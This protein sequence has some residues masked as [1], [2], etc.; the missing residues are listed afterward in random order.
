MGRLEMEL[1]RLGRERAPEGF[2]E[3]VLDAVRADDFAP[4]ETPVGRFY[5]AWNPAG[6]S[7]V[8]LM[9]EAAFRRWFARETGRRLRPAPSVPD[10]VRARILATRGVG[11]A[12]DLR[13][14]T[15][16]ER[17]V[18]MKTLEIP[19]GEVRTYAWVAKE[20]GHPRA[21][22]AV[23][24]ALAQNP[25]PLLIPCHRVVR[26]DGII[27]NYGAGGPANKRALLALEGVEV[28][29][30]EAMARR[31]KRFVGSDTTHV[32]CVPTCRDARRVTE[33]HRVEFSSERA[34]EAA[35]YRACAHCR[36]GGAAAA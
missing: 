24:T 34:A 30:L 8:Q 17:A 36:P 2:A 32:Y 1:E 33:R 23:G 35:G 22:R 10:R 11:A 14:L 21:V 31:G 19:R 12:Y 27:G 9:E 18:L 25:I 3:R 26:S 15:P 6:V 5:V 20:I 7:A 13:S 29:G 4:L 28:A 16:F